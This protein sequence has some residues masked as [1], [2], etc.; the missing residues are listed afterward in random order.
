M[1]WYPLVLISSWPQIQMLVSTR[2]GFRQ[3]WYSAVLIPSRAGIHLS[4]YLPALRV[5]SP[6]KQWY[7]PV[8]VSTSLIFSCLDTQ[9]FRYPPV[10]VSTR[11]D[12]QL[13]WYPAVLIF[14]CPDIHQS[15][16][17]AVANYS[18]PPVLVSTCFYI[19]QSWYP[20]VVNY[21][22]PPV[23]VSTC[24]VIHQSWYPAVANY[25]LPPVLVSACS[26][27]HSELGHGGG[28]VLQDNL[29]LENQ[30]GISTK[31]S[32]GEGE[33]RWVGPE[34]SYLFICTGN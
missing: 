28:G 1:S 6:N 3:S 22:L 4:L 19:H 32:G 30:A 11:P 5:S 27:N 33:G 9:Q 8:L 12:I 25:S 13:S 14:T 23:L 16:Y 10:T 26:D 17:P 7:S 24:S 34:R 20:A 2:P 31:H 15:W 18:L 29:S 21:S